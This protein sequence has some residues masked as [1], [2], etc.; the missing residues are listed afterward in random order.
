MTITSH[1]IHSVLRTYGKQLRRG[2]RINRMRAA[3][4]AAG[5]DRVKISSEAKRRQ[6][7]ERVASEILF[8]LADPGDKRQGVEKEIVDRLSQA[9]GRPLELSFDHEQ[10]LFKFH[11]V[12]ADTG[13]VSD[14]VTGEDAERLQHILVDVTRETVDQTM[15]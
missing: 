1:Q 11:V 8:R 5:P 10:G 9:F 15:M 7:V 4:A 2:M 3:E 14:T 6:V 12:D 13:Y